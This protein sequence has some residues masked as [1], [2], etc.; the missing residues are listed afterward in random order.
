MNPYKGLT[1]EQQHTALDELTKRLWDTQALLEAIQA[2]RVLLLN[3]M[4]EES[5]QPVIKE[6]A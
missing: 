5:H 4:M 1:T 2:S 3:L 6:V